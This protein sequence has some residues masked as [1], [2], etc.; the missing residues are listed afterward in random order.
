MIMHLSSFLFI[1]SSLVYTVFALPVT[2]SEPLVD[3][4]LSNGKVASKSSFSVA[5]SLA[6]KAPLLQQSGPIEQVPILLQK[7][8]SK[9]KGKTPSSAP[10]QRKVKK[11]L[12]K[13]ARR[14]G[15]VSAKKALRIPSPKRA[16][17]PIAC[18]RPVH[19]RSLFGRATPE[20]E[21]I[22]DIEIKAT[23]YHPGPDEGK[24]V[25]KVIKGNS[26]NLGDGSTSTGHSG[27]I[28]ANNAGVYKISGWGTSKGD[29]IAKKIDNPIKKNT[30]MKN[31]KKAG[32]LVAG[33]KLLDNEEIKKMRAL[34]KA[35]HPIPHSEDHSPWLVTPFVPGRR[36]TDTPEYKKAISSSTSKEDCEKFLEDRHQEFA[37][38]VQNLHDTDHKGMLHADLTDGNVHWQFDKGKGTVGLLDFGNMKHSQE[39]KDKLMHR[40]GGSTTPSEYAL[41]RAGAA[42]SK[43]KCQ[44]QAST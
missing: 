29:F 31:L 25:T 37:T 15:L 30:E 12:K 1:A 39:D 2:S 10:A 26:R 16:S 7:R 6:V 17:K 38:Q 8:S 34:E 40:Y 32:L 43:N 44:G 36:L 3:A 18:A 19:P 20:C 11:Q 35:G 5:R 14:Q 24:E 42:W 13:N 21:D 27:V 28:P 23:T 33:S 22:P 41:H 9:G 4:S